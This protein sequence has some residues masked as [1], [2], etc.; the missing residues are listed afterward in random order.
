[1]DNLKTDGKKIEFM[2][3][4]HIYGSGKVVC[5]FSCTSVEGKGIKLRVDCRGDAAEV[6]ISLLT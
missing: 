3:G 6:L 2:L 1:M 4:G 5:K